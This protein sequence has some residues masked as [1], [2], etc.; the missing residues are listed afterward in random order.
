MKYRSNPAHPVKL[1]FKPPRRKYRFLCAR[2]ADLI[3]LI[4]EMEM[5][6]RLQAAPWQIES[7][8]QS[9]HTLEAQLAASLRTLRRGRSGSDL[10]KPLQY[11]GG[12]SRRMGTV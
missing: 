3:S 1:F 10:V 2:R 8:R 9:L 7:L 6:Q 12:R 11:S 5:N 4:S